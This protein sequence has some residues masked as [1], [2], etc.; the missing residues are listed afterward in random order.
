MIDDFHTR[1]RSFT[2]L[3]THYTIG[4][5]ILLLLSS[6]I[7]TNHVFGQSFPKSQ[8]P[9]PGAKAISTPSLTQHPKPRIVIIT[10]PT[11]GEQVPVGKALVISGTSAGNSNSTAINCQVSVIVNGIKPYQPTTPIGPNG[12]GDYSKWNFTLTS[13]YTGLKEG[14][15]KITSKYSCANSPIS[16]H[17]IVNVTG[18]PTN[19]NVTARKT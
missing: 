10:S 5:I 2:K 11:K 14:Q 4:L 3:S 17:N 8:A 18:I 15:N 6:A 1:I 12:P 16:F 9:K 19:V 7:L 13:K